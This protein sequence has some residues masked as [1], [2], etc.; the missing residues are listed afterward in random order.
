M[1]ENSIKKDVSGEYA[2]ER[3]FL[4]SERTMMA[5]L[6]TSLTLIGFG[7]GIYEAFEKS[8]GT[9]T[10]RNSRLVGLSMIL[11]GVIALVLAINQSKQTQ[12][13][14]SEQNFSYK[15]RKSLSIIVAYGLII[16]GLMGA[17]HILVNL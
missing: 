2:K 9:A 17:I 8:G 5:W 11:L 7:I 1:D 12:K 16:I 10:F 14:L 4:A 3:T 13:D 6:R 15:I